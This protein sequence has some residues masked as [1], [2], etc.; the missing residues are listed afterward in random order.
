MQG[1]RRKLPAFCF[2]DIE[3]MTPGISDRE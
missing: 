1:R 2:H 3:M